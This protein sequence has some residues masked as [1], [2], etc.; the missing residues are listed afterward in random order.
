MKGVPDSF[1][2]WVGLEQYRWKWAALPPRVGGPTL[3]GISHKGEIP[4]D[5]FSSSSRFST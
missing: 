2:S 1:E 5:G 4:N 3:T